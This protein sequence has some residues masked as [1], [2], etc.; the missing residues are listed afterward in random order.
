MNLLNKQ[1]LVTGGTG[2]IGSALVNKLISQG[3]NVNIISRNKENAWRIENKYKCRFFA[4]NVQNFSEVEKSINTIEPDIVFHLAGYSTPEKDINAIN[5]TFSVNFNGTKNLLLALNEIDYDLF[6]NTG[7]GNEYGNINP[8]FKETNRENPISPY[9]TSKVAAT[10]LCKMMA[11]I[12]DKPIITVRPFLTY[13]P[14]QIGKMLIPSLIYSCIEKKNLSLTSCEQ[15]RDFVYIEDIVDAY[16]S[17]AKN[18]KKV[19]NRGIFNIASGREIQIIDIVNF[20]KSKFENVQ[21][22]IGDKPYR[23]GE[24]MHFY[25]SIEKIKNSIGW[26]PKWNVEEGINETIKWWLNNRDIWIK[27]K[28]ILD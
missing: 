14:K 23:D 4:V 26:A 5:K 13:G 24:P 22:L 18:Y 28:S 20:I 6:V 12:Y 11:T 21:F 17:L 8:P 19:K 7:T 10:Y 15:Y 16:I 1:I 3:C 27:F 2:F 25:A 9:S